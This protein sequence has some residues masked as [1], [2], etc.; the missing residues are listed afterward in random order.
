MSADLATVAPD[1][2]EIR[3]D[4]WLRRHYRDLPQG[5]IERLCR[6][7]RVR[8]DGE[9][10]SA[11]L[12]LAPG[13]AITVPPLAARAPAPRPAPDPA[14][15]RELASRI[16][17]RDDALLVLDKPANLSVQGGP[18]ITRHLDALAAG[19]VG[20]AAE[21]P[22]LVHRLDRDTAGVLVLALR[23]SAAAK[24]ASAF[25]TH[26]VRK[27]YWAVVLGYPPSPEGRI[28]LPLARTQNPRFGRT[29]VAARDEGK[30]ARTD[31][32]LL[33][34]AA[35]RFSW[36]ELAPLTGRTHQLR[37]HCAA[38]GMPILG[39]AVYGGASGEASAADFPSGLHLFARAIRFPHPDG[40]RLSIE[41][42]LPP[43]F[44]DT[45]A[46]LGFVAPHPAKPRRE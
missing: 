7:G 27:T 8:V 4:R 37:V 10:A 6:T 40:G 21:P 18:G 31:Y 35:R 5:L 29:A 20:P 16:L 9:R 1:E 12:H 22:R 30:S 44:C 39:D 28:D 13:Q 23:A 33:D 3:L 2:A 34:H 38:L 42:P 32:R 19:L 41:A 17:Y 26:A 46:L 24:L 45:F 14:A 25:R 43:H 15:V 11:N 36:L